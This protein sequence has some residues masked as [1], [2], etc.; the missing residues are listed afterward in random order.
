MGP[1]P[2]LQNARFA[3]SA[4]FGLRSWGPPLTKSWIRTC[5]AYGAGFICGFYNKS[6]SHREGQLVSIDV[7]IP[8][9]QWYI[10]K[11][12]RNPVAD[13]RGAP[14]SAPPLGTKILLI[15]CS[16]WENPANLYVGAPPP[17]SWRPLLWGILYPPLSDHDILRIMKIRIC[18][19]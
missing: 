4:T 8:G 15:S 16:F 9:V 19:N 2:R 12:E 17:R 14:R 18:W 5:L 1:G 7:R 13:P 6:V 10:L 11:R 3:T